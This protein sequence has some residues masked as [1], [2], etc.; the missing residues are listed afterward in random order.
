LRSGEDFPGTANGWQ[1]VLA[2]LKN[3]VS[4]QKFRTWFEPIV[5]LAF[6]EK[7]VLLEVPNPFF[8]D[9]FE[10]HNLPLLNAA[11]A[12][13]LGAN[14]QVRFT[15]SPLF[16]EEYDKKRKDQESGNPPS[17]PSN[18]PAKESGDRQP[19]PVSGT[20]FLENR[21]PVASR[22]HNLSQRFTFD[23]FVV[24]RSNE[25]G[26]AACRAVAAKPAKRYNPLFIHG[27]VGL[28]KTHLMHA[29]GN[30]LAAHHTNARMY[31]VSA[32]NFMNEMI[33]SIQ[34]GTTQLF[35]EK[36][37]R[38]DML[39]V[40]DIQ[41][42][43]G[44]ESTQEEFFHTFNALYDTSSQV[45]MTSDRAPKDIPD[46]EERLISRFSWGL[47][48]DIQPP[49]LETRMAILRYRAEADNVVIPDEVIYEMADVIRSNIRELE[50]ALIRVTAFSDLLGSP[51][52]IEL[53]REALQ[54]LVRT[55]EK[56]Q[57]DVSDI[58]RV[59]ARHY[60]VS[61]ESLRGKRRTSEI[62]H[63]RQVAIYTTKEM[64]TLTLMEIGRRFGNR[65]H[66]T[67]LHAVNKIKDLLKSDSEVSSRVQQVLE[68]LDSAREF[69][70]RPT[71]GQSDFGN[72]AG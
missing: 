46:L 44:K 56:K 67:V 63:A 7:E 1:E 53:M 3:R 54:D 68:T 14:P 27:G 38:L 50:G 34:A 70:P 30:E 52:T 36:Y 20:P 33:Q 25:F 35:R 49:D 5:P 45:V 18:S 37:R 47:V 19:A 28:G 61:V 43:A 51:I 42:L 23:C 64:T 58:Q 60:G 65:D 6:S 39:L 24:G 57:I 62:A 66:S 32:E 40:D 41:F 31:Y 72:P 12:S 48:S 55:Q 9:W 2:A 13:V 8:V 15:V 17:P 59:V 4:D 21:N 71:R 11:F 69:P 22:N 16:E 10:E 29:I 26:Y